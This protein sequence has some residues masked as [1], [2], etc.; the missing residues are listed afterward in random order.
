MGKHNRAAW[1]CAGVWGAALGFGA[2]VGCVEVRGLH[3]SLPDPCFDCH[4]DLANG[5]AAPPP[6]F[7]DGSAAADAHQQHLGGADW[8]GRVLCQE[9]HLVPVG[10]L[11]PGHLDSALP[12][13]LVWGPLATADGAT[14]SWD[15]GGCTN[16]YCHGATLANRGDAEVAPRWTGF[17]PEAELCGVACHGEPPAEPHPQRAAC[18]DCHP[19]MVG[20]RQFADPG[21]HI[22]GVVDVVALECDSCHG[23]GGEAAPPADTAGNSATTARGVGAHRAHLATSSWRAA[24]ACSECHL[25]PLDADDPGHRDTPL[26]AELSWGGVATADGAAPSFDGATCA[27]VYCHGATLRGSGTA[28]QPVWTTVDGSQSRCG[29]CHGLPPGGGH[30]ARTDC[31]TCHAAV[32]DAAGTFVAPERHID[33]QV[34]VSATLTC[35]LCHGNAAAD[36]AVPSH[37]APPADLQGSSAVASRGVGAHAAHLRGNFLHAPVACSECHLVPAA[38]GDAGHADSDGPAELVWGALA[39]RGG[40]SPSFDGVRCSNTYCHGAG[41]E[42][43]AGS[44]TAPEWTRES[45]RQADCGSCHGLPPAGDHP[46]AA[47]TE[48]GACH[49]FQAMA[50]IDPATHINGVV[51]F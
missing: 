34:D 43:G 37:W 12:A 7:W 19:S 13:E 46:A 23:G 39:E 29:S 20:E 49:P 32:I 26:P 11:D 45:P 50:P 14:P 42:D 16:V 18:A 41:L 48:C 1:W 2:L 24:V 44:N 5:N 15:G 33:G 40:L 36:P 28:R 47:P 38:L 21:L 9:C 3:S 4:G 6:V 22:N 30:P 17:D 8:R 10:T 27:N 31:A 51:N 25:E 35:N